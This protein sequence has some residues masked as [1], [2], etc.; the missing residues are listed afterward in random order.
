MTSHINLEYFGYVLSWYTAYVKRYTDQ[1]IT[2]P[3]TC[4]IFLISSPEICLANVCPWH[5]KLSCKSGSSSRM[6]KIKSFLSRLR[7]HWYGDMY[8]YMDT[9]LYKSVCIYIYICM[10]NSISCLTLDYMIIIHYPAIVKECWAHLGVGF[11]FWTTYLRWM[12]SQHRESFQL[13]PKREDPGDGKTIHIIPPSV[14]SV[15]IYIYI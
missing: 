9:V 2:K 5:N 7:F 6:G 4:P 3:R 10:Y 15:H 8:V 13:C 1:A 14:V 12:K 11:Y